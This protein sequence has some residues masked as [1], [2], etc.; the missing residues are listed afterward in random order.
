MSDLFNEKNIQKATEMFNMTLRRL[1]IPTPEE[2]KEPTNQQVMQMMI[3]KRFLGFFESNCILGALAGI[4]DTKL[5]ETLR[6][7]LDMI[8]LMISEIKLDEKK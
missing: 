8:E 6:A 5:I 4:D 2:D 1:D 7:F 3:I